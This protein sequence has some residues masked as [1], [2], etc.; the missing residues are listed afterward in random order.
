MPHG[1]GLRINPNSSLPNVRRCLFNIFT[2]TCNTKVRHLRSRDVAYKLGF[3][4]QLHHQPLKM[5]LSTLKMPYHAIE[6]ETRQHLHGEIHTSPEPKWRR[7]AASIFSIRWF[8]RLQ[9]QGV[10]ARGSDYIR[11]DGWFPASL[12]ISSN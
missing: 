5:Q 12:A 6:A 7:S 10:F 11:F 1:L 2:N 9:H 4:Q 3:L 8:E